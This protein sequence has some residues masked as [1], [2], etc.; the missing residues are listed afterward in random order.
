MLTNLH[1]IISSLVLASS[2]ALVGIGYNLAYST[3]RVINFAQGQI[4]MLG[5]MIFA[6]VA[7]TGAPLILAVLT[8][9]AAGALL[10]M[11]IERFVITP[12]MRRGFSHGN[13]QAALLGTVAA[14]IVLTEVANRAWGSKE[15]GAAA[16]FGS[17]SVHIGSFTVG[18]DSLTVI[19]GAILCLVAVWAI[20]Y[21]TSVGL[22]M[23]AVFADPSV[24]MLQGINFR[25]VTT[26][27]FVV[28]GVITAFAGILV[29]PL[30]SVTTSSGLQLS[31]LG[32][33]ATLVGGLGRMWGVVPAAIAIGLSQSFVSYYITNQ[34]AD[35]VTYAGIFVALVAPFW[36]QKLTGGSLSRAWPF[37]RQRA[38]ATA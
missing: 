22:Q 6:T 30:T 29:S 20:L 33:L 12:I 1:L 25:T 34:Y 23:R 28:G 24:T 35:L 9:V 38:A 10:G 8:G 32:I 36:V 14:G 5:A 3:L 18:I 2:Y 11:A 4:Y 26:I 17:G 13:T 37:R 16:L 7:G 15:L 31:I 19:G 21:K 27:S